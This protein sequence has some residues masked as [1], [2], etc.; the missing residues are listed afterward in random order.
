M[1]ML[2]LLYLISVPLNKHNPI[3]Q[4][5]RCLRGLCAFDRSGLKKLYDFWES[6]VCSLSEFRVE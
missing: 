2:R 1:A 5:I 6:G 4:E 3:T